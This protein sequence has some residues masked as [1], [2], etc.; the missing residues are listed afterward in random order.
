MDQAVA[1]R[2]EFNGNAVFVKSATR[3]WAFLH[4]SQVLVAPGARVQ[5]G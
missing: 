1:G 5:A 3:R 4:L 2:G